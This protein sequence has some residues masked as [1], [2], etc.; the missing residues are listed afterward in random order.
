MTRRINVKTRLS[1][2]WVKVKLDKIILSLRLVGLTLSV[3][4]RIF[5]L[6]LLT[7]GRFYTDSE[8]M[9]GLK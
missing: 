5:T 4:G 3:A 9:W 7:I 1:T 8:T 6:I 2:E